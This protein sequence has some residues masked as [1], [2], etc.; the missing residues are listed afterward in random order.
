MRN[1]RK[2]N[3]WKNAISLAKDIYQITEQLP[4]KEKFGLASQL[5]R[6]AVSIASNIAEGASRNSEIEFARFLEISTGSAFEVETQIILASELGYIS[7]DIMEIEVEKCHKLQKQLN[8][9]IQTV[10]PNHKKTK[11]N[12]QPPTANRQQ[13]T[14]NSQK[15]IAKT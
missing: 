1:F 3:V 9:L 4:D 13:P 6:A 5:Q 8:K 7:S 15:P 11:T 12:R 14:A 2:L 10:R